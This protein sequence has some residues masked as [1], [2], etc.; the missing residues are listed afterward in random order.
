MVAN[1]L[2]DKSKLN[3]V[4]VSNNDLGVEGRSGVETV[5]GKDEGRDRQVARSR[6]STDLIQRRSFT[7]LTLFEIGA[8]S[9]FISKYFT[10][11]YY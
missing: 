3:W 5:G 4:D 8:V 10:H 1:A 6:H 11:H 2:K 9:R 7:L